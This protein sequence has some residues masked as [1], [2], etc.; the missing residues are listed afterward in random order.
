MIQRRK[1]N[2]KNQ[3]SAH[4]EDLDDQ[5]VIN[6]IKTPQGMSDLV[7]NEGGV[8]GVETERHYQSHGKQSNK[9]SEKPKLYETLK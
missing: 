8:Y 2:T 7:L 9:N 4:H 5:R 1:K 6:A 3:R